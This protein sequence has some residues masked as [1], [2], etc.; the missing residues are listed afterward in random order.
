MFG[1]GIRMD[2]F[3]LK[4]DKFIQKIKRIKVTI[5]IKTPFIDFSFVPSNVYSLHKIGCFFMIYN[6]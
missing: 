6:L 4:F 3:R 2:M 1:R 5:K